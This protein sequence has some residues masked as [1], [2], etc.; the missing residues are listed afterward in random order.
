MG[1]AITA[2]VTASFAPDTPRHLIAALNRAAGLTP[3]QVA[4]DE[5]F[6]GEVQ[7]SFSVNRAI[8]Y[9]NTSGASPSPRVVTDAVVHQVWELEEAP[10]RRLFVPLAARMEPVRVQLAQLF[11]CEADEVAITRNATD[12]LNTV[13]LG[14]PLNPGDEVLTTTQD[15]WAVLDALDQR[16]RR[17]GI[18][19]KKITLPVS[20]RGMDDLVQAFERGIS[21]TTK[22]ILVTH[23]LN[24]TGQLLCC[25]HHVL[26]HSMYC[27]LDPITCCPDGARAFCFRPVAHG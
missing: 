23:P 21:P 12:A 22:L 7:Q 16:R 19:V 20:P 2:G 25:P 8:T 10:S 15:Y 11:S 6:W 5:S 26:H 4:G 9:L 1:G 17:E 24:L 13:L 18:V 14:I 27:S 3:Q